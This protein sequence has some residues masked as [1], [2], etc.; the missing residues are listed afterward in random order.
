MNG[1]LLEIE[2]SITATHF[3]GALVRNRCSNF[4]F[5]II[6]VYGPA[7]HDFSEDFIT[8][9][10]EFCAGVSLPILMGGDFN[11]IRNDNDSVGM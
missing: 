7:N 11:L 10:G 2:D 8:E 3:I 9:L 1:E 6:N 4:R 5:W